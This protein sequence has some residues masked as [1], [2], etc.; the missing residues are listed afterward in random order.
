MLS[1]VTQI[2]T[3]E[4]HVTTEELAL[5]DLL[6][7]S[8]A[9]LL[10]TTFGAFS[11]YYRKLRRLA[12]EY[13][14]AKTAVSD[15]VVSF[16]KQV[17]RQ[18]EKLDAVIQK[19]MVLASRSSKVQS[20]LEIQGG[21]IT[22][23]STKLNGLLTVKQEPSSQLTTME[24]KI[25]DITKSH[26]GLLAKITS[27]EEK[28]RRLAMSEA[29]IGAVIPIK[30]EKALAPLTPTE[31]AVLETLTNEGEKTA[32]EI[33]AKINLTR[34]HTARLMKK[35]YEA[36]YLERTTGKIPFAYRI[37]EEMRKILKKT[38]VKA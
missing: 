6:L 10:L 38:E 29:N 7:L 33:K 32:P 13:D 8:V 31:L 19:T 5:M 9:V 23:M 35:L 16:N 36:G 21:Q 30:Q 20:E 12:E 1:N 37:K 17:E 14:K 2:I 27:L 24:Q 34:E 11:F 4:S 15:I 26:E 22:Q 25:T 18:E 3:T 28:S